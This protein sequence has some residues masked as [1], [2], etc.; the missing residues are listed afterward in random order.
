MSDDLSS[1]SRSRRC[2]PKAIRKAEH[3][4]LMNEPEQAES[5]CRDVL[6]A[7]P[8]DQERLTVLILALTDRFGGRGWRARHGQRRAGLTTTTSGS[9]TGGWSSSVRAGPCDPGESSVGAYAASATQW[10]GTRRRRGSARRTTIRPSC[11]GTP[12]SARSGERQ[13][14]RRRRKGTAARVGARPRR[15]HDCGQR[16]ERQNGVDGP[17]PSGAGG[18]FG[19]KTLRP[20]R[21]WVAPLTVLVLGS[22][23]LY[24][25]WAAFENSDYYADPYLSPFY[26]PCLASNCEHATCRVRRLVEPFRRRC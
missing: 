23:V 25:T 21:W 20:D 6:D 2:R 24:G 19:P 17:D 8:G 16:E 26:S 9:T 13:V 4:R 1:S 10:T 14:R 5:I 7:E 18:D 22:F 12:A 11:A 15:L 3:Y